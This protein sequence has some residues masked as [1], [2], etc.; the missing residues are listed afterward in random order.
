MSGAIPPRPICNIRVHI[1]NVCLHNLKAICALK[2]TVFW[3]DVML[4][5][6]TFTDINR[7]DFKCYV[8]KQERSDRLKFNYVLYGPNYKQQ[9]SILTTLPSVTSVEA[10]GSNR[11]PLFALHL[12]YLQFS[13]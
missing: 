13:Y 9:T 4:L 5:V 7:R 12:C 8:F 6:H 3:W 10:A 1:H 2:I 11:S